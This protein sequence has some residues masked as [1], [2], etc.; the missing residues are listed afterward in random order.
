MRSLR[1]TACT[2]VLAF[3]AGQAQ[4]GLIVNGSFEQPIVPVGSFTVFTTGSTDV[5]GWTVVGPQ[6]AVVNTNYNT[7]GITFQSQDGN[8]WLDLSGL[9]SNSTADGVTQDVVT[10]I[11][12]RYELSFYVGSATDNNQ[13]FAST[14][15]LSVDGGARRSFTNPTA[16]SDRLDWELFTV[17][18]TATGATTNLTFFFGGEPNNN[19]GA[20]DNVS[21][22]PLASAVPEPSPVVLLGIG[23]AGMAIG[24]GRRC[25]GSRQSDRAS[26]LTTS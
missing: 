21:L 14:V 13:F 2:A 17:P 24:L 1:L 26:E 8:Q 10:T 3:A 25:R 6:V 20:L 18:F 12:Q 4:A 15:D 11:G 19:V 22:A 9:F 16:P 23:A 5:M 7:N